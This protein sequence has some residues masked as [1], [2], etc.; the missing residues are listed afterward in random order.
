MALQCSIIT[1]QVKTL[2]TSPHPSSQ[3]KISMPLQ[4]TII[5]HSVETH[6]HIYTSTQQYL[7]QFL[8]FIPNTTAQ[9]PSP[10]FF[11]QVSP[12][13]VDSKMLFRRIHFWEDDNNLKRRHP[14][15]WGLR[16]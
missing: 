11:A 1:H 15:I 8:K 2:C 5:T 14:Y 16:C 10:F 13:P 4:E 9:A 3:S 6:H 12:G 7:A